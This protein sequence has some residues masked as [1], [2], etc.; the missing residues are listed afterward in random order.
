MKP[1]TSK[2]IK[3]SSSLPLIK[4]KYKILSEESKKEIL[5]FTVDSLSR[6]VNKVREIKIYLDSDFHKGAVDL[7]FL[8][9]IEN[10]YAE[11]YLSKMGFLPTKD[12][13]KKLLAIKP[14]ENCDF[15]LTDEK[16]YIND[17]YKDVKTIYFNKYI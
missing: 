11:Q 8:K 15:L 5:L 3:K 14:I 17:K 7:E 2:E 12:L 13:I 1:L 16:V 4:K 9:G 6:Q 10:E